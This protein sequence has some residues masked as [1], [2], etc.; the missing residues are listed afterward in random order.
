MQRI[1]SDVLLYAR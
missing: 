1:A